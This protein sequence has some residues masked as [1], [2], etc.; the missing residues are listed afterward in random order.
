MRA[1]AC[2][3]HE[4]MVGQPHCCNTEDILL[5]SPS[6]IFAHPEAVPS[7]AAFKLGVQVLLL[8]VCCRTI[9]LQ[10]RESASFV[11]EPTSFTLDSQ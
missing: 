8:R 2:T 1:H 6:W 5:C 10:R 3:P 9:L 7:T 11:N 4:N